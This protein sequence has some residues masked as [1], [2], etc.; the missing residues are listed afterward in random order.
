M[1]A[2]PAVLAGVDLAPILWV[3]DTL[4]VVA[5]DGSGTV[6]DANRAF[7][8]AARRDPRGQPIAG[9]IG[10]G[11]ADA[12]GGWLA[13]IG[14]A[15]EVRTWG[16]LA[17]EHELP[18]DFRMAACRPPGG[19][20]VLLGE[21]LLT[22][23][24]A[25]GLLDVNESMIAEHRR[26]DRERGRLDKVTREDALTGVANRRAFDLR[27]A[28]EAEA[29]STVAGFAVVML[30]I[31]H[32]K[33]LNDTYGHPVGD[34]VLTWLGGLL[35]GAARRSDFVARYGGEEF[36]A[37][38]RDAPLEQAVAWAERLRLAI[39]RE[40]PPSV[41]ERVTASLGVAVWGPGE[42]GSDVLARADRS[43]YR[44]KGEGRDRVGAEG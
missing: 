24:V 37:I 9:F 30:D 5:V 20:V 33:N 1:V 19:S 29:A 42:V 7:V 35:R 36:V 8:R 13:T 39:G 6:I 23:D 40:P 4:I 44:A 41:P 16:A 10:N 25:S 3:S 32:F 28:E 26:I 43:L 31:D 11:Q 2:G 27:L 15:W 38:L 17:D 12:F 21:R 18:I 22:D 34:I 14:P